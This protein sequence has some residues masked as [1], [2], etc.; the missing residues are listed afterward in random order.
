MKKKIFTFIS[1]LAMVVLV[2][3]AWAMPD[4]SSASLKTPGVEKN[5]ILPPAADNSNVISLGSAVD[6]GSDKVV[7]GYA[8]VH[9][10][11]GGNY[12]PNQ[13]GA[14]GGGKGGAGG[15]ASA[16]YTY[17][18]R[19]AKWKS[20]ES[21]VVNAANS[22]LDANF[23]F[24]NL[25]TDIAKWET[26]SG[27]KNILGDGSLTSSVLAADTS[28]PDNQNEVYFASLDPGTIGVTI[29][30]GI[31]G[32]PP[33]GRELV[34]WDQVYNTY[35]IWSG[36]GE[37]EKMDFENIATHELGHSVGLGDLYDSNCSLETMYGYG[38]EG[39]T[40]KRDLNAGDIAGILNLYK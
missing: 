36:S 31:F 6:P 21:W 40:I 14:K 16:C 33:L 20:V 10:Q 34:E 2:G 1:I 8:I 27:G 30:W 37:A 18:A 28:V 4:F 15:G 24:N 29:I 23:V 3:T 25:A 9:P 22:G 39:E 7:E 5:L 17:L 13:A 38:T 19:G 32:G 26:A 35:Y 12:K 11:K